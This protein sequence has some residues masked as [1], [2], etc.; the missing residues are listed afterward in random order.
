[1]ASSSS[2][3]ACLLPEDG[4]FLTKDI[5]EAFSTPAHVTQIAGVKRKAGACGLNGTP[6]TTTFQTFKESSQKKMKILTTFMESSQEKMKKI[7]TAVP[8]PTE[9]DEMQELKAEN[10]KHQARIKQLEDL[11]F[12]H[13]NKTLYFEKIVDS[14]RTKNEELEKKNKELDEDLKDSSVLW[15]EKTAGLE[16]LVDS[17]RTKNEE[18]EQKNK[19]L[20]KDLTD[21]NVF[22]YDERQTV[23]SLRTKNKELE[24][25]IT[26]RMGAALRDQEYDEKMQEKA[27]HEIE[28]FETNATFWEKMYKDCVNKLG[29]SLQEK[30]AQNQ[31]LKEK[32]SILRRRLFAARK[33]S[34]EMRK[35]NK[36][37]M[38]L[39]KQ[40]KIDGNFF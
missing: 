13:Y 9:T 12:H 35:H 30:E 27:D 34:H 29:V 20:D 40:L 19:E 4:A 21:T 14:L 16:E 11:Y 31:E 17:L 8:I 26:E 2:S 24:Q 5:F 23:D 28:K 1:M 15:Y 38:S 39:E 32:C 33:D 22:W 18:L 3:S 25:K 37:M 7:L 36:R 10:T 6:E